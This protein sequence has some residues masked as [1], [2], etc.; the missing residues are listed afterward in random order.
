MKVRRPSLRLVEREVRSDICATCPH[1]TAG[2]DGQGPTVPRPCECGCPLFIRLPQL[3]W[4]AEGVDP[5]VGS[6]RNVLSHYVERVCGR[7]GHR[8]ARL[9]EH[10]EKVIGVLERVVGI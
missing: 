7:G 5:M 8:T 9:R 10:A 4:L 6:R 2:T 3:K 1:R